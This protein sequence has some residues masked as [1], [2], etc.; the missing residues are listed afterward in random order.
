MR[1]ASSIGF[2]GLLLAACDD[3]GVPAH[4]AVAGGDAEIGRALIAAHGCTACHRIPGVRMPVG[5]VGPPL[6]DFGRRAYLS[7]RLPNRPETLTAWLQNPPAID[8]GTAMPALGLDRV[9]AGH[10]AAYLYTLR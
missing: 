10:V 4:L 8:P 6:D 7:G 5:A 3:G 1:F 2:L 9:A